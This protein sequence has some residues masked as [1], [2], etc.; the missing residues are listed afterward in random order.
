VQTLE[1][2]VLPTSGT[3]TLTYDGQTTEAI[4]YNADTATI[5]AALESLLNV[6]PGEI[7]VGGTRVD[8]AGA[9]TFT[10]Q[11]TA[12]DVSMISINTGSLSPS[13]PSSYVFA[14]QAKG[15]N[16][17]WIE[18]SSNTIDDVISGITLHLHD[19]GTVDVTLTRDVQAVKDK[20]NAFI[21]AYNAAVAYIKEKTGYNEALQTG[22]VLMGDYVVSTLHMLLRSP[23]ISQT[24]GFIEDVDSFVNPVHIGLQMD[25][26]GML[27]LNSTVFDEAI[28][29]DYMGVLALLGATKTGS[30]DSNTVRFYG[31][32]NEYTTA[33]QYDVEVTVSGGA[34]SSARIKLSSE[35]TFR[36][37]TVSGNIVIGNSTFNSDGD[38]N[39][40]E[41]GLQL[42]VDLSTDGT[43]TAS[44]YVKQGFAGALEDALNR[45][46][47][48]TDGM[49]TIDKE[50]VDDI[51]EGLR[52][53][54]EDEKDRLD[55]KE[56]RLVARFARLEKSL[57]LI[58]QQLQ[59]LGLG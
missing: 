4:V 38:P 23:V 13:E 40:G 19:T 25:R 43:H 28:A 58:Q 22:G 18:R 26:D 32:S 41:N 36:D 51:I 16:H 24:T 10:F 1:A 27:S 34:I 11:D 56:A 50:H 37:A 2:M 5:Q 53:K 31:A 46:L 39:Y 59:A 48:A 29:D 17:G 45:M 35:S 30:S 42:S 21:N 47:R 55:A 54:I 15:D 57:A 52:D 14:E 7:T 6:S 3:F 12:G 8:Q 20:V 49:V 44:V 33:G 9:T